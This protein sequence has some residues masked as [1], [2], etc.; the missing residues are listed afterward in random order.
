MSWQRL[1]RAKASG[2]LACD[3]FHVDTVLVRRV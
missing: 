3:F 2:L 1:L